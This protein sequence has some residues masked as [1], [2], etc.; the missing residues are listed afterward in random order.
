MHNERVGGG[1]SGRIQRR[2]GG[3]MMKQL[4]ILRVA[5]SNPSSISNPIVF[6]TALWILRLCQ[7][8]RLV[9]VFQSVLWAR[10]R[11]SAA[12]VGV[13]RNA[14]LCLRSGGEAAQ[15]HETFAN[16]RTTAT[17]TRSEGNESLEC[18][19]CRNV[20]VCKNTHSLELRLLHGLLPDYLH[21]FLWCSQYPNSRAH[22]QRALHMIVQR[23]AKCSQ[24]LKR[25]SGSY[26]AG[27]EADE[28]ISYPIPCPNLC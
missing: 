24:G 7:V 9:L 1:P 14:S 20:F 19:Y 11:R 8:K 5:K 6:S 28:V 27:D 13:G 16:P 4:C 25:K 2:R 23:S 26:N 21:S 18:K 12:A 15:W 17:T 3:M 22:V 10:E